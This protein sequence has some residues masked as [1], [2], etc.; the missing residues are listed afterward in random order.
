MTIVDHQH[1]AQLVTLKGKVTS[2]DAIECM[3]NFIDDNPELNFAFVLVSD[4]Y[5]PAEL[6][7]A[8]KAQYLVSPNLP[9][10][11]GEYLTA[12]SNQKDAES[13]QQ[14]KSGDIYNWDQIQTHINSGLSSK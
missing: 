5:E 3:I 9:S 12:F 11:M 10:P 2:Y 4:F 8:K 6:I 7:D 1:A 14:E 13:M